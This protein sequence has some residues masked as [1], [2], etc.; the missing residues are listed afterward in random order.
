MYTLKDFSGYGCSLFKACKFM[1]RQPGIQGFFILNRVFIQ[2][3]RVCAIL[4]VFF[5]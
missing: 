5:H 3:A 1:D 4:Q 2:N